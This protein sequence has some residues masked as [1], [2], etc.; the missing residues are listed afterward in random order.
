[1]KLVRNRTC[2]MPAIVL[3]LLAL[4]GA[5]AGV[6]QAETVGDRLWIWAHAAGVYNDSYLREHPIKSSIEP[7]DAAESMGI[8]NVMMIRYLDNPAPPFE[9]YYTPF[10]R[11]DRV[12]WSLTGAGGI[13]SEEERQQTYRL[14][15]R[16]MNLT[17]FVLDDFFHTSATS[18]VDERPQWLAANNTQFPVELSLRPERPVSA[19]RIE[20]V[21]S[22]WHSGD[23]RTAQFVVE[24]SRDGETFEPVYRGIMPDEGGRGVQLPLPAGAVAALRIRILTTHD[25][26]AARS[27]GLSAV[28]LYDGDARLDT[29]QWRAE[30]T[31]T[32]PGHE[33]ANVLADEATPFPASVT[34]DEL[35]A[36]RDRVRTI[37]RPL[38]IDCVVYTGQIS[39]RAKSH[40]KHVDRM[41]LWTWVPAELDQL[42]ANLARLERLAPGKP[43]LLG[44]Y[45]YDFH[46]SRPLAV[47]RMRV[48]SELGLRWLR[49]GRIEGIIFLGTPVVDVELEAV[50]WTKHWITRVSPIPLERQP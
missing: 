47:E 50:E 26:E 1:M 41:L 30:A 40:L 25:T 4:F 45:M 43:I 17:G 3:F 5:A 8:R 13:T 33:A 22:D 10:R 34:P 37:G 2:K 20:L 35:R 9:A 16:E 48:Q 19:D 31:S 6:V 29:S 12:V 46:E 14:A 38:T 32:Y 21:Q 36:I 27:C 15:E 44:C 24:V 39:P 49:E 7:I 42:E 18:V 11:M 28:R 23:Y